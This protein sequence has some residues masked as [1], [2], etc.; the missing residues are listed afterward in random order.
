MNIAYRLETRGGDS[1]QAALIFQ[2]RCFTYP[3][4]ASAADRAVAGLAAMSVGVGERVALA[5]PNC[6]EWVVAYLAIQ[7]LGAIA[8]GIN[9]A[10][11]PNEQSFILRDSGARILLAGSAL[12]PPPDVPALLDVLTLD[13]TRPSV[14]RDLPEPIGT[15]GVCRAMDSNAPAALLYTSGTTGR[16][17]GVVITH[18]NVIS[19]ALAQNERLGIGPGDRVL[20]CVPL[21]HCFGQNAVLNSALLAGAT[22]VLHDRFTP[23]TILDSLQRDG[24]SIF[25][26]VPPIYAALLPATRGRRFP[27]VSR[28]I[29]GAAPLP[30]ELRRAWHEQ[31]G[32][33]ILEGYGMTEAQYISIGGP[34]SGKE[35][36]VGHPLDGVSVRVVDERGTEIGAGELGE[37]QVCGPNVTPGYWALEDENQAAFTEGWLRT[38][39]LGWKDAEGDLFLVDRLKDIIKSGAISISPREVEGVLRQHPA[40]AAAVVFGA[41]EPLVGEQVAAHVVL[42]DDHSVSVDELLR[43][44]R[45][46]LADFKVPTALQLVRS[47]PSGASGKVMRRLLRDLA[48]VRGGEARPPSELRS[49]EE[50]S[51]W[52]RDW[53]SARLAP[54]ERADL[55][56]SKAVG[57]WTLGQMGMDSLMAVELRQRIL[58]ELGAD[59]SAV[60]LLESKLGELARAIGSAPPQASTAICAPRPEE[61]EV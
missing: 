50:I 41:P 22:V 49:T 24:I 59:V 36:C 54:V 20:L 44:C 51:A 10:L 16:P 5:L 21:A 46:R 58:R 4:L 31:H 15:T 11:S 61:G 13:P 9:P 19:N 56:D 30:L 39:D 32:A 12:S 47:I 42:R 57:S 26:G 55:R 48:G 53:L 45:Q 60:R 2:D 38:G 14:F 18:G 37:L 43:F 1:G 17:K 52:I 3:E 27:S 34:G 40:V 35:G 29:S 25:Y 8:V 7:R 23:R 33:E 6:V 28:W